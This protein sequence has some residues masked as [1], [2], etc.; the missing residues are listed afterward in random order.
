MVEINLQHAGMVGKL[1]FL[2]LSLLSSLTGLH[3]RHN[4][5]FRPVLPGIGLL[6]N[7]TTLDLSQNR[8]VENLPVSMANV[9]CISELDFSLNELTGK[10]PPSLFANW[11]NLV[12]LRLHSINSQDKF[13]V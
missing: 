2:D 9:S 3:T 10:L 4:S 5:L 6:S 7:L 1:K 11:T 8:L 12:S 13:L